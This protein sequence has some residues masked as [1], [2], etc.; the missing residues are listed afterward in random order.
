MAVAAGVGGVRASS[1]MSLK[2]GHRHV[3]QTG[4]VYLPYLHEWTARTHNLVEL[5]ANMSSVFGAEPPVRLNAR[6]FCVFSDADDFKPLV[7]GLLSSEVLPIVTSN[8]NRVQPKSDSGQCD[9]T[10]Q[11]LKLPRRSWTDV[12]PPAS[13]SPCPS[14]NPFVPLLL[15]PS[16]PPLLSPLPT[17]PPLPSPPP[18]PSPVCQLFATPPGGVRPRSTPQ[19][20]P[21]Q[22]PQQAAGTRS[23]F[24]GGAPSTG[25]YF[26]GGPSPYSQQ[27]QPQLQPQPMQVQQRPLPPRPNPEQVRKDK[28][29]AVTAKLQVRGARFRKKNVGKG[30][31][32]GASVRPTEPHTSDVM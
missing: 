21:Q 25:T 27:R 11:P 12:G 31:R 10:L 9:R 7:A 13:P 23:A 28:E 22:Q 20:Q 17:F 19:S 3:D 26:F 29:K 32:D 5:I 8:R 24:S 30:G 4:L 15:P 1:G 2:V 18:F 14:R 16:L 6:K